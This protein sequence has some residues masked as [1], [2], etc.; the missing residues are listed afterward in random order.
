MFRVNN[1]NNVKVKLSAKTTLLAVC[2]ENPVTRK[3]RHILGWAT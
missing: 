2:V 1:V 3:S